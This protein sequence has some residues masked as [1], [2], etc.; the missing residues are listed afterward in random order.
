[1]DAADS[2][3]LVAFLEGVNHFLGFLLLFILGTNNEEIENSND[4]NERHNRH[5]NTA[6]LCRCFLQ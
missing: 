2:H 5:Q 1:M 3:N 4:E 6:L